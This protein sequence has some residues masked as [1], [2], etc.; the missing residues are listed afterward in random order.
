MSIELNKTKEDEN[1]LARE[2][3]KSDKTEEQELADFG[4]ASEVFGLE[5]Y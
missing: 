4:L 5:E 2:C 3:A 1:R